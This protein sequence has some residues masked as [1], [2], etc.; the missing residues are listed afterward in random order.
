MQR[1]LFLVSVTVILIG[2]GSPSTAQY[3][4]SYDVGGGNND[5]GAPVTAVHLISINGVSGPVICNIY[6]GTMWTGRLNFPAN[7]PGTSPIN[8]ITF[9]NATGH[10]PV[11]TAPY[12]NYNIIYMNSTDYITIEGL[13]FSGCEETAICFEGSA[14]DSCREIRMIGNYVHDF[15]TNLYTNSAGILGDY[16]ADCEIIGNEVD[17]DARGIAVWNSNRT[18]IANNMV[19]DCVL[20]INPGWSD[21]IEVFYGT[22]N[23]VCHNSGYS[24]VSDIIYIHESEYITIYNNA[25]Y[26]AYQNI[27]YEYYALGLY[28]STNV[29]SDYNNLYAPISY[30]GWHHYHGYISTLSEWQTLMALDS[31]SISAD[32][33][34]VSVTDLHINDPSPVGVAGIE[35]PEITQDFDGDTRKTPHPDIGADE[36]IFPLVGS[37]DINGGNNDFTTIDEAIAQAIYVGLDGHVYFNVY[38]DTYNGQIEI[39]DIPETNAAATITFQAAAGHTPIITNTT[40]TT[41]T[42][43]NG[44]YL[45]GA[46]FIT[47]QG[48]EIT[49]TAAHGIMNSFNGTDYSTNNRF[50][51]NYIHDVGVHGDYAGIYLLNSPYCEILRNEIDSDHYGI[52]LSTSEHCLIANNM[53]YFASL[54]GIY[55]DEGSDNQYY[56]NSVYQEMNPSTTYNLYLNHGNDIDLMNNVL[57]HSGGGTHYAMSIT[58]D[59]ITYPV[60]SD[61]NDLYAPNAYVGYYN[62]NQATL[63]NWQTATSLDSNSLNLDPD[64]ISLAT[65]DLHCNPT[66][67]L[68]MMGIPIREVTVD[69]DSTMRDESSP[70]IG[71]DE[72]EGTAPPEPVNDL[73]ITLSTSTDDSTDITLIWSPALNAQQYHIYKSITDPNSGFTLI[74]STTDTSFTDTFVIVDLSICFYYVTSDNQSTDTPSTNNY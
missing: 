32:P 14:S 70:D 22:N 7:I 60:T 43:G 38:S 13:E 12:N 33:N 19:Y 27:S 6:S 11:L 23:L 30:V 16:T 49:N 45:T 56:F 58:G 61:Y 71:A 47:I 63:T 52:Q 50:V 42:D 9:R 1:H 8:T 65:P 26:Q 28:S 48:F 51:G 40:G 53:V 59:L 36:Y 24:I 54:S 4:G 15:G 72:F 17:G 74:A 3:S 41:Q 5:F 69:F 46:D 73:V 64:F 20:G 34:F 2:L 68:D 25:L 18:L 35:I 55:D 21:C 57:Y 62:G 39:P 67:P 31:N 10:S 37:Y 66:S 44:F 29:F